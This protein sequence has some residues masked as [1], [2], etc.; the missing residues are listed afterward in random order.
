MPSVAGLT[1][2][3][4]CVQLSGVV[5]PDRGQLYRQRCTPAVY[6]A[7]CHHD[8]LTSVLANCCI[9][10]LTRF[11]LLNCKTY[12]DRQRQTVQRTAILSELQKTGPTGTRKRILRYRGILLICST[13]FNKTSQQ[14]QASW[15]K[16]NTTS[17]T[18]GV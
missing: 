6:C 4:L 16:L 10:F 7:D 5:G 3:G 12:V 11:L 1:G 13:L 15:Q 18:E 14:L 8:T 2:W 17:I 9:T